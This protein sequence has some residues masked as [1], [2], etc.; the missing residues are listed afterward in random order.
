MC[1]PIHSILGRAIEP[2]VTRFLS[3]LPST[4]PIAKGEIRLRGVVVEIDE[5]SGR[6]LR[7]ARVDEPAPS[8]A[9][10]PA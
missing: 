1:G 10:A 8:G 3:N 9:H 5:T 4:F 2:V 6:A 7:I